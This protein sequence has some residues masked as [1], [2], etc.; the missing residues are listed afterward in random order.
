MLMNKGLWGW[1]VVTNLILALAACGGGS[2]GGGGG[3]GITTSISGLAAGG[4]PISSTT[5]SLEDGA[6]HT[7]TATTATDGSFSIDVSGL[8]A[9]FLLSVAG[10]GGT[11]YSYAGAV[12]DTANL[13][14]YTTLLLQAY[15]AVMNTN[16]GSAFA[17]PAGS[18]PI[19]VS[20]LDALQDGLRNVL[21]IY[22]DDA[23]V[24]GASSFDFFTTSFKADHT[25]F[26]Q[27]LDRT[28][29]TSA[30]AFTVDNGSGTNA[31]PVSSSVNIS[32]TPSN[33]GTSASVSFNTST[34][35]GGNTSS[36]QQSV[37]IG[38]S[39]A[40]QNA[41]DNARAGVLQMFASM[42]QTAKSKG[43]NL[44]ASDLD[45][46]VDSMFLDNNQTRLS[47]ENDIVQFFS[48]QNIP[49]GAT[50]T[51][52]IYRLYQFTDNSNTDQSLNVTVDL[53][54]SS[55]GVTKH[56]YLSNGDLGNDGG[57]YHLGASGT[58][59]FYGHQN[60]AQPH[61]QLQ[62]ETF[63]DPNSNADS[64]GLLIQGQVSTDQSLQVTG[65]DVDSTVANS[66]PDCSNF[67]SSNATPMTQ[68]SVSLMKDSGTFNGNQD[69]FDLPCYPSGQPGQS[70]P[71]MID[72]STAPAAGT[73]YTFTIS[74]ANGT[75]E[76][77][78]FTLN[79][80]T[81]EPVY[82]QTIN[83]TDAQTYAASTHASQTAGQTLT[84][85]Y[86]MPSTFPVAY[87]F[88]SAFCQNQNEASASDGGGGAGG[89]MDINGDA[90]Q[91]PAGTNT[92]TIS[93]PSQCDGAAPYT[94]GVSAYFIGTNGEISYAVQNLLSH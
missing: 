75:L 73:P 10:P 7:R 68:S 62:A 22:L 58:W 21:Q 87:S 19:P 23:N 76:T 54:V 50:I 29:L 84:L 69:R 67:N 85:T 57:V 86:S 40:Q 31:G 82:V 72:P 35:D 90:D 81:T 48:S 27:V 74:D 18:F 36:A 4:A 25:G 77:D 14:P 33:G 55:N 64:G 8:S 59:K 32:Q 56:N 88:I 71:I 65:V 15:F 61:I 24:S 17:N 51:P 13:T 37:P 93:I 39:T 41:L 16:A 12:N 70:A 80:V 53:Q 94:L 63:R 11:Y 60:H 5:V 91:I 34:T 28:T 49:S 45:P 26:D 47:M 78:P 6:G 3:G 83:A 79:A 66:L 38:D 9:P 92:G 2:N 44:Q 43:A 52:S 89:G 20:A 42:I 46:Y 1:V 30:S